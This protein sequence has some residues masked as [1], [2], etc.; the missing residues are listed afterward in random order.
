MW[1][2]NYLQS[3]ITCLV[4]L[5]I[6][7]YI[8]TYNNKKECLYYCKHCIFNQI[9]F[10]FYFWYTWEYKYQSDHQVFF[11]CEILFLY[12]CR[13][14]CR[15]RSNFVFTQKFET[16]RFIRF[17]PCLFFLKAFFI[18]LIRSENI[19]ELS[20]QLGLVKCALSFHFLDN[21]N[22]Y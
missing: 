8:F 18:N 15:R 1:Y 20:V 16:S 3:I 2:N 22:R 17:K 7:V 14:D 4:H 21:V 19:W 11:I 9:P 12:H 6:F 5:Y 13:L 10:C